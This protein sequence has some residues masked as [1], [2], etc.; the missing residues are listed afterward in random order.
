MTRISQPYRDL[1]SSGDDRPGSVPVPQAKAC[2]RVGL[3]LLTIIAECAFALLIV[4]LPFAL[5]H[6]AT[7]ISGGS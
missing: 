2:F 4:F 6:F 5:F 1:H 7:L 3:E